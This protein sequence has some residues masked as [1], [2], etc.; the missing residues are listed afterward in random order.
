[1]SCSKINVEILGGFQ[2]SE[3][4]HGTAAAMSARR[5]AGVDHA[6]QSG[7]DYRCAASVMHSTAA[8]SRAARRGPSAGGRRGLSR[9]EGRDADMGRMPG[10]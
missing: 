8:V 10:H 5:M 9:C 7:I 3:P 1:M 4:M 2:P 6:R